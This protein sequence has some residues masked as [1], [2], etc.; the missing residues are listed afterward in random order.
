MKTIVFYTSQTGFTKRYAQWI[1]DAAGA[2]CLELS[3]AKKKD[4]T[5]FDAIIY[6]G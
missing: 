4:M 5:S 2:E 6:G 1:A 3:K